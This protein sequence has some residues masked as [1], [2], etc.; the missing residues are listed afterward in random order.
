MREAGELRERQVQLARR[1]ERLAQELAEVEAE[2]ERLTAARVDARVGAR[3]APCPRWPSLAAE[4][5]Q[6]VATL[7]DRESRLSIAE[8]TLA[9]ARL[10]LAARSSSR[11]ALR[12]LELARE[13]Y[14]AGVRAVFAGGGGA[15]GAASSARWPI[16]WRSSPGWSARSRRSSASGC[17]GSWSSASSTRAP[18]WPGCTSAPPAPPRSCRWRGSAADGGPRPDAAGDFRWAVNHVGARTPGLLAVPA[19]PGG[20]RRSS[21]SG[22]GAVAP[23]RRGRDVRHAGR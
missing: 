4:R 2:A 11:D 23:Q 6:L 9:Q 15:A 10:D 3:A 1:A 12:E 20:H 21:R 5:E 17:S 22:R 13:G 14:G 19:G 16:S 18:R 7:G 8:G